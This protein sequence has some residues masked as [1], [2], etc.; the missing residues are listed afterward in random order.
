MPSSDD[1]LKTFETRV[2]QMLLQFAELKKENASLL[3]SLEASRQ[4]VQELKKRHL[5]LEREFNNY[6]MAR[7]LEISDGDLDSAKDRVSRLIRDVNKCIN[8]LA[9]QK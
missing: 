8:I 9:E 5:A 4:E 1:K 6:K 7:L 2:R 3:E